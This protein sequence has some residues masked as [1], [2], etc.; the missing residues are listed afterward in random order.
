MSNRRPNGERV[1][2]PIPCWLCDSPIKSYADLSTDHV[3][4]QSMGGWRW[5]GNTAWA[6][7]SC[8]AKRSS[9][10]AFSDVLTRRVLLA[11]KDGGPPSFVFSLPSRWGYIAPDK[12]TTFSVLWQITWAAW[13][14]AWRKIPGA[15]VDLRALRAQPRF[16]H[17][18]GRL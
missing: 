18:V 11:N 5:K 2:L 1:R 13:S 17:R 7:K 8:N 15:Q 16:V 9:R 14:T 3:V 6:H 4:P 10:I 12:E